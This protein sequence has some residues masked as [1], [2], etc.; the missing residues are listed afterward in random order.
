M[1]GAA[2]VNQT[3]DNATATVDTMEKKKTTHKLAMW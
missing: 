1:V 3:G 2:Q